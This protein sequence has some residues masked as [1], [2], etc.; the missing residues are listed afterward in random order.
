MNHMQNKDTSEVVTAAT[1]AI[2][3][4]SATPFRTAFK[5]T[6]GIAIAQLTIVLLFLGGCSAL[7][8]ITYYL[9]K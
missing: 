5:I 9:V 2:A 8:G 6:M 3:A 4:S 1:A 7:A